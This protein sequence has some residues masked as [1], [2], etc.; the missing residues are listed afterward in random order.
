MILW[1]IKVWNCLELQKNKIR[2]N[3]KM[4]LANGLIK[5]TKRKKTRM[6]TFMSNKAMNFTNI[7]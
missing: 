6:A 2:N 7:K 1:H 3:K 4:S 5:V